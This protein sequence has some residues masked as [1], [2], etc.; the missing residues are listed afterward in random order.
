MI[1]DFLKDNIDR[2]DWNELSANPGAIPLLEAYPERINWEK[3]LENTEALY[4]F[5]KNPDKIDWFELFNNNRPL[6]NRIYLFEIYF[7]K[8]NWFWLS[9]NDA[10]YKT[11]IS[12]LLFLVCSRILIFILLLIRPYLLPLRQ[13]LSIYFIHYLLYVSDETNKN[14]LWMSLS[15]L[16]EPYLI[17]LLEANLDKLYWNGLSYNPN[18]IHLLEANPEK[19]DWEMLSSNPNA[20]SLLEANPEKINLWFL[21]E[22]PNAIHLIE[23]K[24]EAILEAKPDEIIECIN[25]GNWRKISQINWHGLSSNPSAIHILE[26]NPDK[27]DWKYLSKNT[28]IMDLFNNQPPIMK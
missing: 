15:S 13:Q 3:L 5:E 27:I 2:L 20:I 16:N 28:N 21:Y 23:P 25:L 9:L 14:Y 24:M 4:L 7:N 22:N 12:K 6:K 18:A 8:T 26:S 17:P 19:I 10:I 1:S 11:K